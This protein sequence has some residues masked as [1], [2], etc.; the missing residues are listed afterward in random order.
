MWLLY[1]KYA[2][3]TTYVVKLQEIYAELVNKKAK[4]E[5]QL[6]EISLALSAMAV[7]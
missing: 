4:I 3:W 2:F 6:K 5:E 7:Q 1:M